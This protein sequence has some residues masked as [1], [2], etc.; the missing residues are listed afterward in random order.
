MQL[1][2]EKLGLS[3]E[4]KLSQGVD[5]GCGTGQSAIALFDVANTVTG[6]DPSKQMLAH[7]EKHSNVVYLEGAAEQIPVDDSSSDI[8]TA[9]LAVHWFDVP[10]FL[11]EAARILRP[12]GRLIIYSNNFKAQLIG[13]PAFNGWCHEVYGVQYPT[14]PRK[15]Y[16]P[17]AESFEG[18]AFRWIGSETYEN[19]V[20][21]THC[22]L[23]AYLMTHSNVIAA[24]EQGE[25]DAEEVG[26]WLRQQTAEFFNPG[27]PE[28]FL[29]GGS[30]TYARVKQA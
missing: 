13:N 15:S 24:V 16:N 14:P 23:V 25:Q 20:E 19:R 9:S 12:E 5:V 1:I 3:E 22:Q 4:E 7:A 10:A 30:V 8:V 28:T 18:S 27:S 2:R 26:N 6:I 17:S 29:F 11:N 21:F